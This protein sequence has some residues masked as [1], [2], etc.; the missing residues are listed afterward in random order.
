M[1][2]DQHADLACCIR[3]RRCVVHARITRN[4]QALLTH[5]AAPALAAANRPYTFRSSGSVQ[6]RTALHAGV[7]YHLT[8]R[9]HVKRQSTL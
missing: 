9:F 4:K 7:L 1:Q 3:P 8:A 5:G 2:H 6:L